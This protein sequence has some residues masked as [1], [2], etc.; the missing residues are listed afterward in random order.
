V[1]ESDVC[2]LRGSTATEAAA[3]HR[4]LLFDPNNRRCLF[5]FLFYCFI[6]FSSLFFSM[7][8]NDEQSIYFILI[9]NINIYVNNF[10]K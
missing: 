1:V 10:L 2:S 5:I 9:F 3:I 4:V 8:C 6:F 7:S